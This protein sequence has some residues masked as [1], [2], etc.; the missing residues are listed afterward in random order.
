LK[1]FDILYAL[2]LGRNLGCHG[3]DAKDISHQVKETIESFKIKVWGE[4]DA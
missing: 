3:Y 2:I 1:V 4:K